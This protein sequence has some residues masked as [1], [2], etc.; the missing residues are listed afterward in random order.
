ML[1]IVSSECYISRNSKSF[2]C[3][4]CDKPNGM[5]SGKIAGSRSPCY[6]MSNV[7][8][9]AIDC[10]QFEWERERLHNETR[11]TILVQGYACGSRKKYNLT[12]RYTHWL[13]SPS[14][15]HCLRTVFF[16]YCDATT[17]IKQSSMWKNFCAD[18][19]NL[20]A[21]FAANTKKSF[22]KTN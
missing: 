10:M 13:C 18:Y 8:M 12:K 20:F 5:C 4:W 6:A 14:N 2:Y 9:F 11:L 17:E 15:F 1:S 7:W 3:N 21:E 16:L 22:T 19:G